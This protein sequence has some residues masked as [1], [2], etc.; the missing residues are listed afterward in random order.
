MISLMSAL[1]FFGT[2]CRAKSK[3]ALD[4]LAAADGF[5][6]DDIQVVAHLGLSMRSLLQIAA[7][8][9][10]GRQRIVDLVRHSGG[11]SPQGGELI[12]L[13]ELQPRLC[14]VIGHI[15]EGPGQ[16]PQLVVSLHVDP[17]PKIPAGHMPRRREEFLDRS[18]DPPPDHE[19]DDKAQ[20][21]DGADGENDYR[22]LA[23]TD[24]P[25]DFGE[26][27]GDIQHSEH[28][29]RSGVRMTGRRPARLRIVDRV[30]DAQQPR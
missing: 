27:Y 10:Y 5:G 14:Q 8:G 6:N 28:G 17:V 20:N 4:D 25:I 24:V 16:H 2:V 12:R 11:Q 18:V 3:Q 22:H 1:R 7:V 13:K 9:E 19:A 30:D 21:E 23:A 29:L 26:G 15:I